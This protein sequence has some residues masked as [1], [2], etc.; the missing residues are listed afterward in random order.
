MSFTLTVPWNLASLAKI[1]LESLHVNTT[2]IRNTWDC[3]KSTAQSE[4]GTSAVL[5]QSGLD[6]FGERIPWSVTAIC[7][8]FRITF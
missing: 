5:S 2:Q 6:M 3:R 7:E 1:I 8:I 4:E